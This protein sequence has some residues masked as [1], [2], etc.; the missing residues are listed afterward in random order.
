LA[1][2]TADQALAAWDQITNAFGGAC[3]VGVTVSEDG[4]GIDAAEAAAIN[5]RVR[6]RS[7]VV[8]EWAERS[9]SDRGRYLGAD[10]IHPT[11]EGEELFAS[12]V[13]EAVDSCPG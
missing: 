1:D 4:D 7:D 13:A 8:V 2:L 9:G 3:I 5:A 6:E 12:M 11:P 10:G